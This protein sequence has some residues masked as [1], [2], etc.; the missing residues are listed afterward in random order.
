MGKRTLAAQLVRKLRND[1]P[2]L[3]H[4]SGRCEQEGARAYRGI[5][6]VIDALSRY[7]VTQDASSIATLLPADAAL[8][9]RLFPSMLRVAL[10]ESTTRN[11][12]EAPAIR[13]AAMRVLRSLLRDLSKRHPML[14][15]IDDVQWA[16]VDALSVVEELI[17][18]P[19]HQTC[20]YC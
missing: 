8:L 9:A 1:Y 11:P 3:V 20:S 2:H 12:Q 16:D 15:V 5:S 4:L 18:C 7:L 6:G 13:R 17:A 10:P 19:I 14:I